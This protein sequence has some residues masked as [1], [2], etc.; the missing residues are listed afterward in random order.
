VVSLSRR[1]ALL[2]GSG[3]AAVVLVGAIVFWL[4]VA[5]EDRTEP[6]LGGELLVAGTSLEP[7]GHLFGERVTARL[8]IVYD[9][10]QVRADT[11]AVGP[12]FAPYTVVG[13]QESR[14]SFGNVARIRQEYLLD[15]LR[16]RCLAPKR[17]FFEFP[18]VRLEYATTLGPGT[19]PASAEWPQLRVASQTGADDL[20][21]LR[22]R[23]D[24]G[25]LPVVTYRVRPALIAGVGY[26]LAVVLALA[27][28]VLLARAL[29]VR[30]LL[31]GAVARRRALSPLERALALVRRAT[32]RGELDGS[33]RALE[34]LAK[35]LRQ[36]KESDLA[37]AATRLAW[38]RDQ[39]SGATVDPLST[40]VE[41]RIAEDSR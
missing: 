40:E 3:V 5:G 14:E 9:A 34:R 2:L 28:A 32:A 35:E 12:R 1:T 23:A 4:A 15:C 41:R 8:D 17:G 21:G 31:A 29:S 26:S 25:D 38:R 33:R 24:V 16:A 13:R 6:V 18:R 36:T 7:Q 11:I 27:G 39:P 37:H 20:E 22:V 30:E 19:Q 10:E